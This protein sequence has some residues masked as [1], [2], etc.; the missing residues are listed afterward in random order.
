MNINAAVICVVLLAALSPVVS[1]GADTAANANGNAPVAPNP[2]PAFMTGGDISELARDEQAGAVYKDHGKPGDVL[3]MFKARGCNL[4]RLRLWVHPTDQGEMINDLPYTVALGK[5]IK[6]SGFRLLLDLHYSDTWADPGHQETPA[7]WKNLSFD[8]LLKQVH[9]YSRSTIIAMR[10][11]GSMPDMVE[12]GN[13]ISNGMMWP[14]GHVEDPGGWARLN[15]LIRA[16]ISGVRDGSPPAAPP[17][18]MLHLASGAEPGIADWFYGNLESAENGG[19]ID[20][21]VM[22]VSY[23]PE[24]SRTLDDLKAALTNTANKYR[25]PIIVVETAYPSG[26][27]PARPNQKVYAQYGMTPDGQAKYLTDLIATVKSVPDTYGRGVL[28]WAPEWIGRP[29][30][31]AYANCPLFDSDF[32][33]LPALD[34]LRPN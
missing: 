4:M 25:K 28:Y 6:Q 33:A 7:A 17:Q 1:A 20:F 15:K 31:P 13:E 2:L 32:N 12:V 9:D 18:I 30:L 8:D 26:Y 34:S 3:A 29:G 22:G 11:G 10:R 14:S 23:Y 21:D 27:G 16:G 24:G 19:P 5:R